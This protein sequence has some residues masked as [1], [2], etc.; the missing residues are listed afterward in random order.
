MTNIK[1]VFSLILAFCLA[2]CALPLMS[3][4]VKG[5]V[6]IT[7]KNGDSMAIADA[8]DPSDE[9]L[10]NK[11]YKSYV[12]LVMIESQRLIAALYDLDGEAAEKKLLTG[13]F[14]VKTA[15]DPLIYSAMAQME[16]D[17]GS[18][19][20]NVGCAITDYSGNLCAVFS[21]GEQN[22]AATPQSP[23]S[24]FKPLSVYAPAMEKGIIDWSTMYVDMPYLS[25]D[26]GRGNY[27]DWPKNASGPDKRRC[28]RARADPDR[29]PDRSR[30]WVRRSPERC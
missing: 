17:L 24:S 3:C 15:F 12:Q 23:H 1:K 19:T 7:D 6:F 18:E 4:K 21:S 26:D 16:R 14:T 8:I 20:M 9:S 11:G 13:G 27:T 2:L 10:S 22:F 5:E 30:R 28:Q 29:W 25:L